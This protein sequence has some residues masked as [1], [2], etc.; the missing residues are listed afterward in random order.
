MTTA[1]GSI[2]TPSKSR[3]WC[4]RIHELQASDKLAEAAEVMAEH[5]AALQLRLLQTVVEVAAEKNSTLVLPFPVEL[6]R[7]LEKATPNQGGAQKTVGATSAGAVPFH[8]GQTPNADTPTIYDDTRCLPRQCCGPALPAESVAS[9]A[10]DIAC[11]STRRAVVKARQ[12]REPL[13]SGR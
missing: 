10:P 7:F 13:E 6:L 8:N 11:R 12:T 3:T 5:P 9:E 4:C 1:G 2:L